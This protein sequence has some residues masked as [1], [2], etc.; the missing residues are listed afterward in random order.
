[1]FPF[2]QIPSGGFAKPIKIS[3]VELSALSITYRTYGFDF[4][5]QNI[6]QSEIELSR[7]KMK[8]KTFIIRFLATVVCFASFAMAGVL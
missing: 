6:V 7:K 3:N 1:M 4:F 2:Q 5:A 8:L